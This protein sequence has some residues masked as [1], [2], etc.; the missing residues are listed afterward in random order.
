MKEDLLSHLKESPLMHHHCQIQKESLHYLS[1]SFPLNEEG[2]PLAWLFHSSLFPQCYWEESLAGWRSAMAGQLYDSPLLPRYI[3]G[4]E[5]IYTRST[6]FQD[7][8]SSRFFIPRIS[9]DEDEGGQKIVIRGKSREEISHFIPSLSKAPLPSLFPFE[10]RIDAPS[11]SGWEERIEE[12]LLAIQRGQL[13]KVVAARATHFQ[14]APHPYS[15]LSALRRAKEETYYFSYV[16]SPEEALF[17]GASPETLYR[18]HRNHIWGT[19]LAGTVPYGN[20][21]Q[22]LMRQKER[23]EIDSV[24]RGV[25]NALH[26]L[27]EHC[28]VATSPSLHTTPTTHHLAAPFLALLKQDVD[29]LSI[30]ASLH[31]TPAVG[32]E[33][34]QYALDWIAQNEPFSRQYYGAPIGWITSE[35]SHLVVGIRSGLYQEGKSTLFAG[36]GIVAGSSP[37]EEWQELDQKILLFLQAGNGK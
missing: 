13:T 5:R 25:W 28:E 8:H 7:P 30:I 17:F 24:C 26:P 20:E 4:E 3:E 22:L 19:P 35:E 31:P 36:A 29:D 33:P 16:P 2:D 37:Q 11:L 9:F 15:L 32:G 18:R 21:E 14:K 10:G 12:A 1:F 23:R 34:K 6:C 27:S